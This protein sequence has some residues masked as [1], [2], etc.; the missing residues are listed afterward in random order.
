MSLGVLYT[1][2]NVQDIKEVK[3]CVCI[4][5]CDFCLADNILNVLWNAEYNERN[6]FRCVQQTYIKVMF[7]MCSVL[8]SDLGYQGTLSHT[9]LNVLS[10][11]RNSSFFS[12]PF[13]FTFIEKLRYIRILRRSF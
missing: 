11:S 6:I 5:A 13:L 2:V 3:L 4:I 7:M 1:S 10:S 9:L 12:F 8:L